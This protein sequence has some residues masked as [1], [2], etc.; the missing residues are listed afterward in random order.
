MIDDSAGGLPRTQPH[1]S[2]RQM[3]LAEIDETRDG[4]RVGTSRNRR[5]FDFVVLAGS[6]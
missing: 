2:G 6:G 1:G 5:V 3:I 4:G